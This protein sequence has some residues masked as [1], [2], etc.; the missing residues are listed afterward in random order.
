VR[1]ELEDSALLF[2]LERVHGRLSK[3]RAEVFAETKVF[4]IGLSRTGTTSLA[5]ALTLLGIDTAHWTNPLTQQIISEIDI[6]MFGACADCCVSPEFEKLYYLYPNARFILTR[7][8]VEDWVRSFWQHHARTSW[9]RNR[10]EFR[11]A[12]SER[13]F[14]DAAVEFALYAESSD[15]AQS[16]RSFEK[17][18]RDFFADKPAGKLLQLDVFAGEGWPELCGFLGRPVPDTPFPRLNGLS[19]AHAQ[20]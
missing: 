2:A 5:Q 9:V 15:I 6:F 4:G 17:R 7:R 19:T 11:R 1:A 16:Y 8:A 12:F 13:P 18:V 14:P 10:E 20:S 3:P